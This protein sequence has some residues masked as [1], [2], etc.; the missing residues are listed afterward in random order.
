MQVSPEQQ[1]GPSSLG[2]EFSPFRFS[3]LPCCLVDK[4]YVIRA[5]NLSFEASLPF[6]CGDSLRAAF[7][8]QGM[9][10]CSEQTG[11]ILYGS[12]ERNGD[13]VPVMVSCT[14][15]LRGQR[16]VLAEIWSGTAFKD[17][18]MSRLRTAAYSVLRLNGRWTVIFATPAR[19]L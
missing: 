5:V 8:L 18:E 15:S 16:T 6:K 1:D 19:D 9:D 17:A 4:N 11:S 13:R 7:D 3:P 12:F 14:R 10:L 2:E